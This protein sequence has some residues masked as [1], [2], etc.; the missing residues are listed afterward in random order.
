MGNFD[1]KKYL[2][3]G[4]IFKEQQENIVDFLKQNF[5]E[6][7]YSI[8]DYADEEDIT[9]DALVTGAYLEADGEPIESDQVA[10]LQDLGLDFSFD[11]QYVESFDEEGSSEF[12]IEIDGKT[13]YGLA[14]NE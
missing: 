10:H 7:K 8:R 5:D 14:Y 2:A 1:L 11:R 12:E 3:E 4:R 13:I 9:P 6:F